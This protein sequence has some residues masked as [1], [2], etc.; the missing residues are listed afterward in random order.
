[1]NIEKY[2][3]ARKARRALRDIEQVIKSAALEAVKEHRTTMVEAGMENELEEIIDEF[4]NNRFKSIEAAKAEADMRM[5]AQS[6]IRFWSNIVMQA[7]KLKMLS[8]S[9]KKSEIPPI[10]SHEVE[11]QPQTISKIELRNSNQNQS[12]AIWQIAEN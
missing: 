8:L 10:V 2:K 11:L 5:K 4:W 6:S 9:R 12:I 7:L 1:M 3:N